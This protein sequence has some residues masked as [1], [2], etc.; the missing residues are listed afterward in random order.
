MSDATDLELNLV[1]IGGGGPPVPK[2]EM[3]DWHI[4]FDSM[5]LLLYDKEIGSFVYW[6]GIM[7]LLTSIILGMIL[8]YW[9]YTLKKE[10]S[11]PEKLT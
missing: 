2:E 1:T 6:L 7:T 8:V 5:G 10:K 3:H 9:M 4:L 11:K